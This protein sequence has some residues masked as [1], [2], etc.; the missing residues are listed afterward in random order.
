[1]PRSAEDAVGLAL[2]PGQ[3]APSRGA[4]MPAHQ[5]AE[6]APSPGPGCLG[7]QMFKG[8]WVQ[9]GKANSARGYVYARLQVG[10]A[11]QSKVH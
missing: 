6:A 9:Q 4:A 7:Q 2:R 11:G 8:V 1:M 5:V 3:Q 10:A